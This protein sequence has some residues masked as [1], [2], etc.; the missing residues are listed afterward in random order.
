MRSDDAKKH[1]GHSPYHIDIRLSFDQRI[2]DH[3]LCDML[4]DMRLAIQTNYPIMEIKVIGDDTLCTSK[5]LNHG[6]EHRE[7][8]VPS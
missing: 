7:S 3:V 1:P 4:E 6:H 2:Q 5:L 8:V